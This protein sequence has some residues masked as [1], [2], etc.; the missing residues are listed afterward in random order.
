MVRRLADQNEKYL[1]SWQ[2][3]CDQ[4]KRPVLD[5]SDPFFAGEGTFSNSG[6]NAQHDRQ[7]ELPFA[8]DVD[9]LLSPFLRVRGRSMGAR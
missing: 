5:L 3:I 2:F 6:R 9:P 7:G 4:G 8:N 1:C